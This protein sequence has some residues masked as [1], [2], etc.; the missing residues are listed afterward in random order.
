[1]LR[2]AFAVRANSLKEAAPEDLMT[3]SQAVRVSPPDAQPPAPRPHD[4]LLD[5]P[6]LPRLLRMATPNALAIGAGMAV[7]IAETSYV[8]RLGT[9]PLAAMALVF[10][11]I[12]VTMT[13]SGGAMGGGVT[14]AIA[15]ALGARDDARAS[16]LALHA[17]MIA[18]CFGATFTVVMLAFGRELLTLLGGRGRVLEQAMSY[19][20][21][22]FAGAI[23]PWLMQTCSS[24]LR[25]TGNMKLPSALV[26]S[27]AAIQITLGGALALGLG[28]FPQLG[29]SGVA[30][31]TLAAFSVSILVMSWFLASGNSRVKLSLKG[32]RFRKEMFSDILKVGA[33]SVFSPLQSVVTVT[34]LTSMLA[35][36][37]NE[38]LAG[39]GIGTRLE[40]MLTSIAFAIGVSATPMVGMAIGAGRV[41][42][43]R[44][45]AW[46]AGAA[47]FVALGVIGTL[48]SIF[49]ELWVSMFTDDPAVRDASR[50]YLH[51]SSP[52][53]SFIGLSMGLYFASQ[54]AAKIIGPV[55]SQTVRLV[56]VVVGGSL[57]TAADASD[58]S[59][60]ML[61]AGSMVALGLGTALAVYLTSW[62][63]KPAK[64]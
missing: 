31:G 39:Y 4:P 14:S 64:N 35:R 28:P 62:D 57:L 19:V 32:F 48:I 53:L 54:G 17:L 8:G 46:I 3:K 45:V 15:R 21:I 56:F 25:G 34:I 16:A 60:F 41:A 50:R 22:F 6:I 51:V 61:A 7:V 33:V 59:F 47:A 23:I 55:L 58:T 38:V 5:D 52:M 10:P 42:R 18:V 44:R 43:A 36:F 27:S 11:F 9:E 20:H 37:G 40:F 63:A 12:M 29:L 24:I 13:M 2:G 1:M 30:T 49:P 26:F